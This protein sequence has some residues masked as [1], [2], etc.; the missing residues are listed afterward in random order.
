VSFAPDYIGV[1]NQFSITSA[2]ILVSMSGCAE[3]V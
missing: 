1:K 3:P 2:G